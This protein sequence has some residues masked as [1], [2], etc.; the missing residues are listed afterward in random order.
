M[1][2]LKADILSPIYHPQCSQVSLFAL[3]IRLAFP[4]YLNVSIDTRSFSHME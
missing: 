1:A 4:S 2:I 3:F